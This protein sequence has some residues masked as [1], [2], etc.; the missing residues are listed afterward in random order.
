MAKVI[1]NPVVQ[2]I[3]GAVGNLVFRQMPDGSTYVSAK[4]DFSHRKFSEGQKE[5]Q[6]RFQRAVAYAREAAKSQPIYGELAA[7]TIKSAYNFALSDWFNPP[8]IHCVE[9]KDGLIRVAASDNV[10]VTRVVVTILDGDGNVIEK[11]EAV[12]VD[13]RWW[14][15]AASVDGKVEAEVW[16]LAE[17]VVREI[18]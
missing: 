15:Y 5:H 2:G 8:V 10:M 1:R 12:K 16:D 14:E 18:L 11:G 17:N 9:R 4:P 7:G 13:E 3:S 6:S